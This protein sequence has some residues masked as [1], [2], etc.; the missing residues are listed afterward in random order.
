M[1]TVRGSIC[2][3]DGID[4]IEE[5]WEE[6]ALNACSENVAHNQRTSKRIK[7]KTMNRFKKWGHTARRLLHGYLADEGAKSYDDW[8]KDPAAETHI[9][10]GAKILRATQNGEAVADYFNRNQVPVGP[11]AR[12]EKWDGTMVLRFY[13]N[14]LLKGMPQRGR[15]MSVKHHGSGKRSS[16]KN[17]KGPT[18]YHAPHLA[19]FDPVEFDDLVQLL[20]VKNQHY[21]RK[22]V[23]GVDPRTCVPRKRTR[24]PGQHAR[25]WYCGRN[26]NWGGNGIA[27]HL[28]CAGS[29]KYLCWN[30]VHIDGNLVLNRVCSAI[31]DTLYQL[32][33][34]DHQF[35]QIVD[36][37]HRDV[38]DNVPEQLK[39]I[40]TEEIQLAR[41]KANL[42]AT[43]KAYGPKSMVLQEV[44]LIESRERLL[45]RQ[46]YQ[47]EKSAEQ[48]QF[49]LPRSVSE[50]RAGLESQFA[51]LNFDSPEFGNLL[52][53]IVPE[54]DVYLVRLIDGGHLMPRA[55]VKM[56]FSGIAA[57]VARVP[58]LDDMLTRVMTIDLFEPP[59]RER[60][61]TE[62]VRLESEGLMQRQI[63]QA[64]EEGP[65][66]A[67]VQNAL[68]LH[69][70]M[71]EQGLVS[72]YIIVRKPPEDYRK[73]RRYRHDR[74]EFKPLDGYGPLEI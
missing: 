57:D 29:H 10:E 7:Q 1:T 8:R 71:N 73:L 25:C 23:N 41:D 58:E 70:Q 6:D 33:G 48:K 37:A 36:A 2:I 40:E 59:Q 62:A 34:F 4:T 27:G 13:R 53:Q 46:R 43:L 30:S 5:T 47:V 38:N 50:L 68:N 20:S 18:Y 35:Q 74:Y 12:N 11:S 39:Q 61:R 19:Y 63:A 17:P 31:T 54:F 16:K 21:R 26:Y 42:I 56:K 28:M 67:A 45:A 55:Y 66:Q 69:R 22:M 44:D 49:E 60:I 65:K 72:P 24:F 15:M 32:E 52:R 9:L 14:P 3:D 51:G 64:I